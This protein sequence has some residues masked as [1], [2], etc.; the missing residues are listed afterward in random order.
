M[1]N[2]LLVPCRYCGA[3]AGQ[4]CVTSAGRPYGGTGN[5]HA[6][7]ARDVRAAEGEAEAREGEETTCVVCGEPFS[8][9]AFPC[10]AELHRLLAAAQARIERARQ[11]LV[12]FTHEMPTLR[13]WENF[14]GAM[15]ELEGE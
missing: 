7:R 1:A 13:T 10:H 3:A 6:I 5:V 14:N 9:A 4:P 8:N 2:S 12:R 11:H 15:N